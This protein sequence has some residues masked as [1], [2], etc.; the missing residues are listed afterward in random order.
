MTCP[1][2]AERR[3][4]ILHAWQERKIAE[5]VRLAAGGVKE[6]VR[7]KKC[8]HEFMRQETNEYGEY[9]YNCPECG[10]NGTSPAPLMDG[11]P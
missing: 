9:E 8:R 3:A 5:A 11:E 4:A 1:T 7:G 10:V 6:M 2:C